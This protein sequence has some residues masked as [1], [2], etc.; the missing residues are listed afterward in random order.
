MIIGGIGMFG[1][2]RVWKCEWMEHEIAQDGKMVREKSDCVH[3]DVKDKNKCLYCLLDV[4]S[5]RLER[6]SENLTN[7]QKSP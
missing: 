7:P 1:K 4:V 3:S 2:K 6:I 5:I